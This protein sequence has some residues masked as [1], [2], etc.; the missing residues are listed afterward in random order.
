[1]NSHTSLRRRPRI[2]VIDDDEMILEVY[3]EV[4]EA[5]GY[6]VS[7]CDSALDALHYFQ[8]QPGAF[9]AIVTDYRMPELDGIRFASR[10]KAW[11]IAL[12]PIF[13]VTG[14]PDVAALLRPAQEAGIRAVLSKPI[15]FFRLV[16]CLKSLD[17]DG[18]ALTA[19]DTRRT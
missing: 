1:M 4:L 10:L 5:C 11:G 7:T 18:D 13:L 6:R 14:E 19:S 9:V 16:D 8:T 17:D 12:P 2:L 15:S 3:R